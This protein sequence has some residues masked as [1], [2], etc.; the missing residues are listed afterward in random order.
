MY[1]ELR[2]LAAPYLEGRSPHTLQP[3]SVTGSLDATATITITPASCG[4]GGGCFCAHGG[5]GC[6]DALCCTEVCV[7]DPACCSN[8]WDSACATAANSLCGC[9]ADIDGD[10]SVGGADLASLLG[11]WGLCS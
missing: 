2:A 1:G 11:G 4:S 6:D 9:R 8:A 7:A 10:G 3:P 5:A